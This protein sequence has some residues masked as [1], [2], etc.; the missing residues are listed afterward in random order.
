[1][2]LADVLHSKCSGVIRAGSSPATGTTCKRPV[3]GRL[4][5]FILDTFKNVFAQVIP[6]YLQK[7]LCF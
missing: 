7:Q 5:V 1:M 2:E 3:L 6:S 4:R